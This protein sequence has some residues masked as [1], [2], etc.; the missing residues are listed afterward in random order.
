MNRQRRPSL[1]ERESRAIK[2]E[3]LRRRKRIKKRRKE[4][5]LRIGLILVIL[6]AL[7]FA[8]RKITSSNKRIASDIET[9]IKSYDEGYFDKNME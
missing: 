6:L 2:R 3:E 1:D 7:V 8:V 4:R 9:A 5:I